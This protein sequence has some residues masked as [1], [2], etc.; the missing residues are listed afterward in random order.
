MSDFIWFLIIGILFVILGLVFLRLGLAIWKKQK[1]RLMIRHHMDKVST[2]DR[3]AY[4]RLCG[5]GL[6]VAGTGF[7]LSGIWMLFTDDPVS[8]IPAA[9]G[10]AAGILLMAAAVIKYNH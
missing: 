3:Q 9:T 2:A 8:W 1:I 7:V 6:M 5:I 10:L 4:C